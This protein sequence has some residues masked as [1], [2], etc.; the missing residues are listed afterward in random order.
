MLK[1]ALLSLTLLGGQ[2]VVPVSDRVPKFNVEAMC[3]AT[4]DDDKANGIALPQSF[5]AC[6]HDETN[7]QQQLN[8]I[9]LDNRGTV[10]DRREAEA[11]IG[12][13]RSY[14]DLLTCMQMA[15]LASGPQS[16][17]PLKG[18]SNKRNTK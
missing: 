6:M 10:R 1:A 12:D 3:K 8:A 17:T 7:A 14:V 18:A 16:P 5:E 15:G 2:S 13:T 9:W 11:S 4:V